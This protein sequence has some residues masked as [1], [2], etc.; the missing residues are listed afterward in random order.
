MDTDKGFNIVY[1]QNCDD[2]VAGVHSAGS[3]MS[4]RRR[5]ANTQYL[6]SVPLLVCQIWAK[7]SGTRVG[8]REFTKYARQKL[9]TGDY[10]KFK[11]FM[12]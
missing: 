10:A 7:E 4:K 11:V 1:K 12:T 6:G 3:A 8:S 2:V 9:T 5:N